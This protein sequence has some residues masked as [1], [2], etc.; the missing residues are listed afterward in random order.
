MP[1]SWCG[2]HNWGWLQSRAHARCSRHAIFSTSHI[3]SEHELHEMAAGLRELE[4]EY[5]IALEKAA[6]RA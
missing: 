6:A 3:A 2:V 4:K 1:S 5:N